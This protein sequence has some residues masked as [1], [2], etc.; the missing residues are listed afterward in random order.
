MRIQLKMSK[1]FAIFAIRRPFF[2]ISTTKGDLNLG[3]CNSGLV[4]D[5]NL[6]IRNAF[7][8]EPK[9][10]YPF[11]LLLNLGQG[12]F[13]YPANYISKSCHPTVDGLCDFKN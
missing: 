12:C 6:G 9:F 8:V 3:I 4:D 2:F 13:K 10:R 5:L 7:L 11:L 1:I